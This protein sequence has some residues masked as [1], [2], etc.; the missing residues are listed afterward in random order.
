MT[1]ALKKQLIFILTAFQLALISAAA[2]A[3]DAIPFSDKIVMGRLDNGLTYYIRRNDF[4]SDKVEFRLNVRSGSLNETDKELGIAHFVE[5]MAF[6][7]TKNFP[8]NSVIKYMEDAGLV[9]GKD[10]NAYTSSENTN[11]QLTVPASDRVL[12]EKAFAVMRDWADGILFNEA[13]IESEKGVIIEEW[14]MRS[15]LR[16]RISAQSRKYLL[17]GSLY[18]DRDPIGSVDIIKNADKALLEGYY[19][20]WY[21]PGN[22]SVVVVGNI[23]PEK[24][25]E[26]IER[27]FASMKKRDTPKKAD[28]SVPL[29]EG[30]RVNVISDPEAKGVS[31]SIVFFEKGE[32][33]SDFAG[34]KKLSLQEGTSAMLN[35]RMALKINEKKSGLLS[36]RSGVSQTNGGLR[37]SVFNA[38]FQEGAFD[39]SLREFVSEIER[40]RRHGFYLNELKEFRDGNMTFLERAASPDFKYPSAKYAEGICEYDNFGGYLTEFSQDA[41]LFKRFFDGVNLVSFNR[42]FA[43]RVSSGSVLLTVT[44]PD[45]ERKSINIDAASFEKLLADVSGA[46]IAAEKNDVKAV[47]LIKGDIKSGDLKSR[48]NIDNIDA[49]AAVYDNGVRLVVKRNGEEKNRFVMAARKKGGLS[50][51]G[52]EEARLFPV[53]VKAVSSSGFKDVSKRQLNAFMSGRQATL[54]LK[55]SE[56]TFD[57]DGMG[58]TRDIESFFQLLHKYFTDAYID[59]DVL[60]AVARGF[61]NEIKIDGADRKKGFFRKIA[62]DMY[63]DAYRRTY[64]LAGDMTAATSERLMKIYK[65]CFSDPENFVF[66]FS[67]DSDPGKIIELGAKYLGSLKPSGKKASVKSRGL[68]IRNGFAE[69]KGEVE[70]KAE[71]SI[72]MDRRVKDDEL[73]RYKIFP[74]R[75]ALRI[76]LRQA[77]REEMSGVY[78]VNLILRYSDFPVTDFTG[79]ISFTCDPERKEEILNKTVEVVNGFIKNGISAEE[80]EAA[81]KAQKNAF[82]SSARENK[83]WA[84]AIAHDMLSGRKPLSVEELEK[85]A[86]SQSVEDINKFIADTLKGYDSFTAVYGPEETE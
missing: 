26:L 14:R 13:D 70:N 32:R 55:A 86:E 40:A 53:M 65:D 57:F 38:S 78:S 18:P 63:N 33:P 58:D 9:F 76:R 50:A 52:D 21:T 66:V 10:S 41:E 15:D 7:G 83:Y 75:N 34:F 27:Y 39:E 62:P 82:E 17:A 5:H 42:A 48:V 72:F 80:L 30:V 74:V 60:S 4:P 61:E 24:A 2:C 8:G 73:G 37:M 56:Y 54:S 45:K 23:E 11:Y 6:N 19:K 1:I 68:E 3:S 49:V 22:M 28:S 44:V 67:A 36:F 43:D 85:A 79:R 46:E 20:K 25:R 64:L 71:V 35:N 51:L 81:K 12:L 47:N 84:S 29:T 59:P 31:A 77:V 69:G 16:K